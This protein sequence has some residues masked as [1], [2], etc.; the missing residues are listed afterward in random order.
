MMRTTSAWFL[1][2]SALIAT[3]PVRAQAYDPAYPVCLQS[4]GIPGSYISCTYTSLAQC[5]LSA[6]GQAAQCVTN[7]YFGQVSRRR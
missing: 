4:Y 3:S 5:K 1:A 2:V 7:P 6:S